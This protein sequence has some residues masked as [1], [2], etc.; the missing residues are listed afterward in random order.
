VHGLLQVTCGVDGAGPLFRLAV[1]LGRQEHP[2]GNCA[3]DSIPPSAQGTVNNSHIHFR[4][5]ASLR[6]SSR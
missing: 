2:P 4:T 3:L 6:A 5:A 1:G